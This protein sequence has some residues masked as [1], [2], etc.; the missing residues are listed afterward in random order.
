MLYRSFK[1]IT[2]LEV[3]GTCLDLNRTN[4][5]RNLPTSAI[6]LFAST[7]TRKIDISKTRIILLTEE[8]G[9]NIGPSTIPNVSDNHT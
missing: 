6:R 1:I 5:I 8:D 2:Q 7:G 3:L 9:L 4:E